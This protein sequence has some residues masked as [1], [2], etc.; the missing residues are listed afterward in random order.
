[1]LQLVQHPN[2][3]TVHKIYSDKAN[4]H[5][6]H[7][8]IPR[9]LQKA[10]DNLFLNHQRL[11]TI[12]SQAVEALVYLERVG[13][14][15]GQLSCSC[16]LIYLSGRVKLS[17]QEIRRPR[18]RRKDLGD[19]GYPMME[20]MQGYVKEGA[21]FGPDGPKH[22]GLEVV[23]FL[24]ATTAATSAGELSEVGLRRC[25]VKSATDV[26]LAFFPAF[27]AKRKVERTGHG[28]DS[29]RI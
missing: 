13:S 22:W 7:K 12:S 9:S 20:L 14:Q 3:V 8:R 26:S 27:V 5:I 4:R 17:G 21:N 16:I 6:T 15:H 28:M 24:S 1:M 23:S 10:I 2:I 25:L 18:S 11:T 19:L 29:A